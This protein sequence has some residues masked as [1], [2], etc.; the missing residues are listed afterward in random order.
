MKLPFHLFLALFAL[1]FV[2]CGYDDSAIIDRIENLEQNQNTKIATIN[3]QIEAINNSIASLEAAKTDLDQRIKDA[4]ADA[5]AN[6]EDIAELQEAKVFLWERIT[7]LQSYVD[8]ELNNANE[9]ASATFATLEQYNALAEDVAQLKDVVDGLDEVLKNWVNEQLDG[10]YTIA[11]VDAMLEALQK[12]VDEN[13]ESLQ[14]DIEELSTKVDNM[15]AELTDAYTKAIEEAISTNNGVIDG[16]IAEAIAAANGRIDSEVAAINAR[17]SAL[18][19]RIEELEEALDKIKA[20]DIVFDIESG[21]ACMAGASI[22]FGYTIVGGDEDTEVESFGDRGW[23][24][25]VIATDATSGRIRVTAPKDG[26]NGKVIVLATSGAGGSTMKSIRF[27]EGILTDIADRYEVDWEA[28][29]LA[30]RLKT[31]VDYEVR[32]PAEAQSW[33]SVADTRAEMREDTLTFSVAENPEDSPARTVVVELISEF[34]E[35]L[36]SF[37]IAQKMQPLSDPIQFADQYVKKVCVEKFDTNGDGELSYKEAAAVTDLG[38][39][40]FGDYALAVKSFDELQYFVNIVSIGS[41]AFSDCSKLTNITVPEGVNSIGDSSFSGCSGLISVTIPES[42]V[43]IGSYAFI[44]CSSLTSITIPEGVTSIGSGTFYGCSSLTSITIP[45]GVVS[46]GYETFSGCSSLTSITIPESVTSIGGSAFEGCDSLTSVNIPESVTTIGGSAF[47]GCS[48]LTSITIPEGVTSIGGGTFAGCNN[49]KEVIIPDSVI[50][51]GEIISEDFIYTG[52]F[53]DCVSLEKIDLPENVFI[54]GVSSFSG[55][56]NLTSITI[57]ESVI[58]IGRSAFSGCSSLTSITI[59]ES[60]TTIGDSSFSGCSGL[61]SVTI[62]EGVTSIGSFAF[63]GC[64]SLSSIT[65][66]EGVIS[67]EGGIFCNCSSLE[68]VII[69]ESV[70]SIGNSAFEGCSSLISVT[71]PKGVI[72]IGSDTF[73]NC[74]NLTSI[75]IHEGITSIG[76][77]AFYGCSSLTSITIPEGV[78]SIGIFA[79]SGCS[80]L[81]SITIPEGVTSIGGGAFSGCSSLTSIT[82]PEGVTSIGDRAFSSCTSLTSIT[83]P[84]SVVSIGSGTFSYCS[85]LT[86]VYCNSTTPPA[87]DGGNIFINNAIVYVP[88]ESIDAYI[89]SIY[90]YK[91]RIVG[92]NVQTGEILKPEL[93]FNISVTDIE[94][95]SAAIKIVPSNNIDAFCWVVMEWDGIATAE[96]VMNDIVHEYGAWMNNGMMLY[97]GVQDYTGSQSSEYK[98]HL[99]A[100]ATDYLVIAFGYDGGITTEP[101][102]VTFCTL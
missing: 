15:K 1:L 93:A 25:D 85:S 73:Y 94:S 63:Y 62:P 13:N 66:P 82:I 40:L 20:L 51:I 96:E 50:R 52:V 47:Y 64:S 92:Y 67:I 17:I 99:D 91:C 39:Y 27:E 72:E 12:S 77:R 81:I 45:E 75:T 83:I 102:M 38:S 70:V 9:W 80:S 84:E 61:I 26:G 11:E 46:I 3:E 18:E 7:T 8:N 32:I 54:I 89:T 65:I 78:T 21:K 42:V 30:V 6:A 49:L 97:Y 56:S 33:L 37:E 22:E 60:V 34:G 90:W 79:F 41:Y 4:Q 44:G 87:V 53:A 2:G 14:K 69:P 100:P 28:C 88:I 74:T 23:G 55:C 57:P 10:Y 101:M 98:Y 43:S 95:D 48:S 24:A 29:T 35:V 59:P 16:K 36:Q 68:S 58:E 86:S 71:I 31:N 19:E 76:D 5:N